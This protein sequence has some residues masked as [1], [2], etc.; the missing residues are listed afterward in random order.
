MSETRNE[1]YVGNS[2]RCDAFQFPSLQPSR[3]FR[4]P[5]EARPNSRIRINLG[6]DGRLL[7]C[8]TQGSPISAFNATSTQLIAQFP[9]DEGVV[10]A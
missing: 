3:T 1:L 4:I 7:L 8:G 9:L 2:T 5:L 6:Y 10:G